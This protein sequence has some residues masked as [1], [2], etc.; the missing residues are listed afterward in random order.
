MDS[1]LPMVRNMKFVF[2]GEDLV[3][4]V[5]GNPGASMFLNAISVTFPQ[6][7]RFHIDSVKAF[8]SD[9]DDEDTRR[10]ISVFFGQEAVHS[11][12]HLSCNAE[13]TRMGHDVAWMET[14]FGT[15][16]EKLRRTASREYCLAVTCAYEHIT[17]VMADIL[18]KDKEWLR[19]ARDSDV[20]RFWL[21]HASEEVEHKSVA[22]DMFAT[23]KLGLRGYCLRTW[24][25]VWVTAFFMFSGFRNMKVMMAGGSFARRS[26]LWGGALKFL[27][28]RPG[29]LTRAIPGLALYFV[30]GFHPDWISGSDERAV[31]EDTLAGIPDRLTQPSV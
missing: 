10:R 6:G 27:L 1:A 12:E 15:H 17:A 25:L 31:W 26:R 13:L 5:G 24:A 2:R 22:Y 14:K 16:L 19:G 8:L 29:L 28:F 3:D 9:V 23:R 20:L 18:L 30:P 21:W 7:E 11:R 4:W